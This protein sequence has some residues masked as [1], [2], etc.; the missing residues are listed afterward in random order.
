MSCWFLERH[1]IPP[2]WLMGKEGSGGWNWHASV[3]RGF[4]AVSWRAVLS[5]LH[6]S[7][8]TVSGPWTT[9]IRVTWSVFPA[10]L[11]LGRAG[12]CVV[13]CYWY[14]CILG[15]ASPCLENSAVFHFFQKERPRL[16]FIIIIIFKICWLRHLACG[17]LVPPPGIKPTTPGVEAWS[18]RHWTIREVQETCT[19]WRQ[20]ESLPT[21]G[22][23]LQV[24]NSPVPSQV[25]CAQADLGISWYSSH[26]ENTLSPSRHQVLEA[27]IWVVKEWY[28]SSVGRRNHTCSGNSQRWTRGDSWSIRAGEDL[29]CHPSCPATENV[30]GPMAPAFHLVRNAESGV[31][32]R[33]SES[34][35]AFPCKWPGNL[36]MY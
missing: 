31:C 34:E 14:L 24:E 30:H 35:P 2:L 17:N 19:F 15:F 29:R 3:W 12:I 9:G 4:L 10:R 33:I 22:S 20:V 36:W 11:E 27:P 32:Y 5:S 7:S 16:S 26:G 8:G 13:S 25:F 28:M 23:A 6:S 18:V 21:Q 1:L